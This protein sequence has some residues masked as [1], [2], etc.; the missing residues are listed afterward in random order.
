MR[1]RSE[2]LLVRGGGRAAELKDRRVGL[3]SRHD[4]GNRL[5][6]IFDIGRLQSGPAAAEHRIDRKPAKEREDGAEERVVRSE[7]HGR[8]DDKCIGEFRADRPFTFAALSDVEGWRGGVGTDPRN[9]NKPFDSRP[10]GLGCHKLSRL[11]VNGVKRL[12]SALAIK[13]DRVHGA[14]GADQRI[15]DG[16]LVVNVGRHGLKLH[17]RMT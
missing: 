1:D 14:V 15:R 11:D 13:A 3:G 5:R 2:Q 4:S 16:S 7:H 17:V 12:P 8:A 9:V 6:N 10:V